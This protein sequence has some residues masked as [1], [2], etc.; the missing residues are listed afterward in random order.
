MRCEKLKIPYQLGLYDKPEALL[1]YA[2]R[3]G[4]DLARAVYLGN[5]VNDL[6][7]MQHV[8][9]P[10][11]VADALPSVLSQARIVLTHPGGFGAVRE[12]CD[13]ILQ[14]MNEDS[15]RGGQ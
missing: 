11:A 9:C 14:R 12:L 8:G 13:L 1:R 10:A 15:E 2:A 6:G 7:C 4:I 3:E 5:D